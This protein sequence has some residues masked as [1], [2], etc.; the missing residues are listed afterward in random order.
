MLQSR[1]SRA[2]IS[3]ATLSVFS[4]SGITPFLVHHHLWLF[5]PYLAFLMGFTYLSL[6]WTLK[7][8]P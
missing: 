7:G 3:L 2:I 4:G 6:R 1:D 5:V 8:K